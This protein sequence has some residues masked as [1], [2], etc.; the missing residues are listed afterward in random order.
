MERKIKLMVVD[1]EQVVLDSVAKILKKEGYE[2]VGIS[3]APEALSSIRSDPPDIILTDLMMPE[4]DGLQLM[5]EVAQI[6]PQIPMIMITGYATINTALQATELGAFDY[7]T[8]PF[9]RAE[10]KAV[11]ARAADLVRSNSTGGQNTEKT[12][13]ESVDKVKPIKHVG[14]NVWMMVEEDGIVLLGVE[15][16]FLATIGRIQTIVLPSVGD[17]LRQGSGYV[18]FFTSELRSHTLLSPLSGTVTEINEAMQKNPDNIIEDPYGAG[19]LIRLKPT[20]FEIE[21]KEL[22]L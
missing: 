3:S 16:P 7:V 1:D 12:D 6:A 19:W 2:I 10:L 13:E 17:V 15:R 21:I 14:D 22:G 4:I 9:T 11:V 8:K 18:Q 20:R 5:K